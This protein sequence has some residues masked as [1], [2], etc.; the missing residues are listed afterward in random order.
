[1]SEPIPIDEELYDKWRNLL[2]SAAP[3]VVPLLEQHNKDPKV[4]EAQHARLVEAIR[5]LGKAP[6]KA[7]NAL[8]EQKM[9]RDW[10]GRVALTKTTMA[11][12]REA[13]TP[14]QKQA[15]DELQTVAEEMKAAGNAMQMGLS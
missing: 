12:Y 5:Q 4:P 3:H 9:F 11:A 8:I 14:E 13:A 10:Y 2:E 15:I 1:V 7:G 6:R